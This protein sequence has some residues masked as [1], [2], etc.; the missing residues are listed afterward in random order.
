MAQRCWVGSNNR[1]YCRNSAWN[2]WVRWVVLV[3]VIV[4]FFLLFVA[5]SCIT[6]RR[7]RRAGQQPFYGTGW[8]AK[9]NNAQPYY[10]NTNNYNQPAP[11]YA[12]NAPQNSYYGANQGYY[13]QQPYGNQQ[14]GVEMQPP[15]PTYHR[16]DGDNVYAPPA[17]PPPGKV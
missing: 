14:Q 12:P 8:A 2:D 17:G 16:G 11:P 1:T 5:C 6:A 7:R 13:G 15:A 3:V 4:G 10:N 9:P